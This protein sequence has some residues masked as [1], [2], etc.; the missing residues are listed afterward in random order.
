MMARIWLLGAVLVLF[1]GCA[2]A[3]HAVSAQAEIVAAHQPERFAFY[4]AAAEGCYSHPTFEEWSE[5]MVLARGVAHAADSYRHTLET[6]QAA[7]RAGNGGSAV[8]C[9]I[10]A[11]VELTR[12]LAA[13]QVPIPAE[14]RALADLVP[15]GVCHE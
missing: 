11:A 2:T 7:I 6:A 12:A 10:L 4:R 9:V 8:P 15:E 13:A 3:Q 1:A 5:C 14:V